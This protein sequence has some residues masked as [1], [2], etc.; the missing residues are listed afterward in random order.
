M[1]KK[2]KSKVTKTPQ[3]T[4]ESLAKSVEWLR[5]VED[6]RR[7][8]GLGYHNGVLC[9]V[10][11]KNQNAFNPARIES[12]PVS[13]AESA[14]RLKF[15]IDYERTFGDSSTT[16]DSAQLRWLSELETKLAA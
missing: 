2:A 5:C 8:Y 10:T 13:L 14:E 4:F 1:S 12:E 3:P 15:I 16:D 7:V 11:I 6:S 9:E